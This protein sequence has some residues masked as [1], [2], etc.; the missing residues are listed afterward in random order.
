MDVR[1]QNNTGGIAEVKDLQSHFGETNIAK[2]K[3]NL[4]LSGV[5]ETDCI[6]GGVACFSFSQNYHSSKLPERPDA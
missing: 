5:F 2:S 1:A 4:S 6:Q 3:S